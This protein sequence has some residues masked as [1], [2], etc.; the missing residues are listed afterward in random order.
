MLRVSLALLAIVCLAS[1]S[2]VAD[3][4]KA[5]STAAAVRDG[6]CQSC[7]GVLGDSSD[8]SVPRLNGQSAAYLYDRLHSLRY[9]ISESPRAI[10]NMGA[11]APELATQTIAAL[12]NY[13]AG[14]APTRPHPV[15]PAAA[16]GERIYKF[17]AGKDIPACQSCHGAAGEGG[18]KAPRLAGQHAKYLDLQLQAFAMA[19]RI[20][21]P[22]NHHIWVMTPDQMHAVAA[23]LG[24]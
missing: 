8:P 2:A 21:D 6:S 7:H 3:T 19:A 17:G 16:E 13:Y 18:G 12:A 9:P 24:G 22:M 14:Q 4:S 5:Q 11:I 23:F 10:H 20:S 15:G 1:A